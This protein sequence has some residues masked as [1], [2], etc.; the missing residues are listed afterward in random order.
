MSAEPIEPEPGPAMRRSSCGGCVVE[1]NGA[2]V[3]ARASGAI[4]LADHGVLA[5]GD[6]H[7]EK[8]SAYGVRGQLLP[9]YDTLA[10]LERLEAEVAATNAR[11]VILMGDSFHDAGGESRLSAEVVARIEALVVGRTLVW[12]AGNHD[13]DAP[14]SLPGEAAAEVRL[15]RLVLTHEPAEGR[16][17]G[18]VS[19]H[20]HPVA[21]LARYGQRVRRRCFLTDG[22]RMILPAFGAYAGGLN[23]AD[24]AFAGL[25]GRPPT[26]LLLGDGRVHAVSWARL[27]PGR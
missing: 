21:T 17:P 4:W 14:V 7:F 19:G 23:A 22:E 2:A 13:E 26:A 11:T 18:E 3:T 10:T 6:L 1:V 27:S 8:G 20:L 24:R 25:F 16:A 15:G 5:A 12:I 9:P